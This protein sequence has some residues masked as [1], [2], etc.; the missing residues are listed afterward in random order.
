MT[1]SPVTGAGSAHNVV[2]DDLQRRDVGDESSSA[3]TTFSR[4]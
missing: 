1:V 2:R 3:T 4:C